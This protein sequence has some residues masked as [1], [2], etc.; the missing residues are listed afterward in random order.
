M[1]FDAIATRLWQYTGRPSDTYGR[2]Q[3]VEAAAGTAT[4]ILSQS[5]AL[6][7][8]FDDGLDPYGANGIGGFATPGRISRRG[9]TA[10][11][12]S[13]GMARSLSR[14][15]S[16]LDGYG[17][18]YDTGSM[19]GGA[20]SVYG[21][22]G[23]VYGGSGSVYGDD[24]DG[25][26]DGYNSNA[27]ARRRSFSTL[28]SAYA[29]SAPLPMTPNAS[30]ASPTYAQP[31]SYGSYGYASGYSTPAYSPVTI[32][33]TPSRRRSHSRHRRHRHGSSSGYYVSNSVPYGY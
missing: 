9:S 21:G 10:S 7:G 27:L 15:A 16:P 5:W 32:L 8:G 14:P 28:G 19:Y 2:L 24:Y 25:V 33:Q 1:S 12:R 6:N 4:R 17:G 30:Y 31:S 23:S 22:G 11:L 18:G 3:A 26:Y 20:G 13:L 29:P